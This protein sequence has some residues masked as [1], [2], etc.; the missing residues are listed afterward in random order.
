M[1]IIMHDPIG[2]Y[3]GLDRTGISSVYPVLETLLTGVPVYDTINPLAIL[4][5]GGYN[6]IISPLGLDVVLPIF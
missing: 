4:A 6:P 1:R 2:H 5:A 3:I